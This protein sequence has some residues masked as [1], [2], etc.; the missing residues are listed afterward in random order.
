VPIYVGI[1]LV[2]PDEVRES[3]EAHGDSYLHRIYTTREAAECGRD[4]RALAGRFA[5][6][7]AA[8]KALGSSEAQ[9]PWNS[10][11]VR[12]C[13]ATDLEI[14]LSGPAEELARRRGVDGLTVSVTT[15]RKSLA[16][17]VVLATGRTV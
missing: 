8:M 11:E 17:A 2:H 4:P 14:A 12:S 5:A 3:L 13:G 7:E 9:L 10:I 6:K 1:D 15:Q 16:A